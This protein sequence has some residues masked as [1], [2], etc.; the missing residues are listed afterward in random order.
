MKTLILYGTRNG[1]TRKSSMVIA[2]VLQ[3]RGYVVDVFEN[4]VPLSIIKQLS[5]Y[6]LVIA[7]SSIMAGL[8]KHSVR[9][10]LKRH[11]KGLQNFYVFVT[12][13]G[14]MQIV[15]TKNAAKEDAVKEATRHISPLV[16]KYSLNLK[17][18]A[19]F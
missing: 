18:I 8:W 12:A 10:F 6:S 5:E 9:S 13:G 14:I 11:G 7:G 15:Q 19:V 16:G 17:G 3:S 2:D 4:K 1:C